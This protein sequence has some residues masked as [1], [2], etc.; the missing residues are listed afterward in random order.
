MILSKPILS[1]IGLGLVAVVSIVTL[2]LPDLPLH[3]IGAMALVMLALLYLTARSLSG[4]FKALRQMEEERDSLKARLATLE[5]SES[6]YRELSETIADWYWET[7]SEQRFTWIS[8]EFETTIGIPPTN[9]LGKRR[10]DVASERMEIDSEQWQA[11]IADLTAHRPFRDFK[12]WLE[13]GGRRP[14]WVKVNGIPRFHPDGSFAGY[15][16]T[17]TDI[18]AAVETAHRMHMLNRAVEQSPVSI[19]ITDLS[20]KIQYVNSEFIKITGYDAD[21]VMGRNPRILKSDKTPPETYAA[22]WAALSAGE[23]WEGELINRRK[24]GEL[25]WELA[26]IQPIQNVEGEITNFL[27]IKTDIT[28]QKLN[29]ARLADLVEELHRSNQELEQFAYVASHDLRQPL[30]MI[31]GYLGMLFKTL[32]PSLNDDTR[33]FFGFAIDGAKRLDRMIIDLLEYS[34]IGRQNDPLEPIDLN[35]VLQDATRHLEVAIAEQQGDVVVAAHLPT[36]SGDRS[37]LVRLFQNLIG[38]AIKYCAPDRPP[39]VKVSCA[40]TGAEWVMSVTDNGIGIAEGDLQRVFGVFQ[41]LVTR[42]Q[43]EGTGIG[44]AVCRKIAE[45]HGG[46]IWVESVPDQGSTFLVAFPKGGPVHQADKSGINAHI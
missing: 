6:R 19:V 45:H 23:K 15:R 40:D 8:D 24:T 35:Q 30:R 4:A 36:V 9:L 18:T 3:A 14:R 11:H 25:Y 21:E 1:T 37:E 20:A 12:Y 46:R 16:G 41:R 44:L 10:W 32:Q 7:D 34:R 38:N 29:E 33:T 42:E 22:M 28:Q 26:S 13:D 2:S 39:R 5:E 17:G 27:A 43:Y 31:S